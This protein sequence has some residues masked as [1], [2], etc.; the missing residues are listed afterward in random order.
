MARINHSLLTAG[1]LLATSTGPSYKKQGEPKKM[2]FTAKRQ[3][4][5]YARLARKKGR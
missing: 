2:T 3:K 4:A 1:L 5:E